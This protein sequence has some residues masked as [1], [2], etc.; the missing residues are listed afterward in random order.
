MPP[1][2]KI[3][4]KKPSLMISGMKPDKSMLSAIIFPPA[5]ADHCSAADM[6]VLLLFAHESLR[7][8]ALDTK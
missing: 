4:T 1:V 8:F 2:V 7:I 6:F 5:A 3:M